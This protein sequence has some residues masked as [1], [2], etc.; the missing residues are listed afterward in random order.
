MTFA[1]AINHEGKFSSLVGMKVEIPVA[2]ATRLITDVV[3]E[4]MTT[5]IEGIASEVVVTADARRLNK[6]AVIFLL[7]LAA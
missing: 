4:S 1:A 5:A 7:A 6:I 2:V 3:G